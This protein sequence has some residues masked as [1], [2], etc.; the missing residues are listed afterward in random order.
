[1]G[2]G[3]ASGLNQHSSS[4]DLVTVLQEAVCTALGGVA[5]TAVSG[6]VLA[7]AGAGTAGLAKVQRDAEAVWH[8]VGLGGAPIVVPDVVATF[9]GGASEPAGIVLVAGTGAIAAAVRGMELVRQADGYGWWLGDIGSAVWLGHEAVTAALGDLDGRSRGTALTRPVLQ[10]LGHASDAQ[11]VV[12]EV[13]A[14]RPARLGILARI[15]TEQAVAGDSVAAD[16]VQRGVAGLLA[17]LDAVSTTG[18]EPT[19]LGGA[20]LTTEGPVRDG[21]REGLSA[22]GITDVRTTMDAAYGAVTLALRLSSAPG[23][24]V[25]QPRKRCAD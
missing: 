7:V 3:H 12:R 10:A 5:P 13:Y 24:E 21:V 1:M 11:D 19:V 4:G 2:V 23:S 17:S 16:I 14:A 9:A 8:A 22:R 20:L 6:G 25:P 15:V 18:N